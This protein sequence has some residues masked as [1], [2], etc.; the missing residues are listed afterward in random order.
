MAAT[1]D[2][3][4]VDADHKAA[5]GRPVADQ[6]SLWSAPAGYRAP[7]GELNTTDGP[8][9]LVRSADDVRFKRFKPGIYL[10][11]QYTA[12]DPGDEVNG[13]PRVITRPDGVR[14]IRIAGGVYQQGDF[15]PGTPMDD[16]KQGPC[17][18]HS[19]EVADFYIQETEVTNAEIAQF[20]EPDAK[21][22][23]WQQVFR[24]LSSD[25]TESV[26]LKYPAVGLNSATA[27]RY[28]QSVGGRLPTEAEWEYAA[29][30]AGQDRLWASKRRAKGA[31]PKASLIEANSETPAP[32][33]SYKGED[34]TDQHLFD[35]TGNAREWC[36]DPYRTY[37]ELL[38]NHSDKDQA[39]KDPGLGVE[40]TSV[41]PN[42]ERV[43]RGGS[44][45][46]DYQSAITF[47]RDAVKAAEEN[48]D[49]G[50]RVVIECPRLTSSK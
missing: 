28:A 16:K 18:P 35:F 30:S 29:R 41:D 9:T 3:A 50:F 33:M 22:D 42:L 12:V 37:A 36:R 24:Q 4:K 45:L 10:P 7:A 6:A 47:N 2:A 40:S 25:V 17:T 27:G 19:V 11:E 15:R 23:K 8:L 49:L 34:E 14:L 32:V 21:R 38:Q 1:P 46:L 39:I 26:A 5:V 44:F 20:I 48:I 31:R 13:F 43:V